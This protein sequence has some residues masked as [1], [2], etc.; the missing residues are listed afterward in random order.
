M[1]G[2]GERLAATRTSERFG[3]LD[4]S[5]VKSDH[6]ID[7]ESS[8]NNIPQLICPSVALRIQGRKVVI[9]ELSTWLESGEEVKGR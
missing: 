7:T 8:E 1:V 2:A 5:K 6:E 9:D 3:L 4:I